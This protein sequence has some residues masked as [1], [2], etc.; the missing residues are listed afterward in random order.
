MGLAVQKISMWGIGKI[1]ELWGETTNHIGG[2]E[3]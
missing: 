1:L 3:I 2:I